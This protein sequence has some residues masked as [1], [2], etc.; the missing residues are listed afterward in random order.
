MKIEDITK[1]I[2]KKLGKEETAK[3]ADDVANL[4]VL[5][6]TRLKEISQKDE[7]IAELIKTK[8]MLINANSNLLLQVPMGKDED[9]ERDKPKEEPRK[10]SFRDVFDEK[11]NFKR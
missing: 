5:E 7:E 9:L 3:I 10:F 11:G 4:M 6:D 2:S 1:S 8:E